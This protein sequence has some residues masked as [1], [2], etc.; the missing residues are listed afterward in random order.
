MHICS[1]CGSCSA[2]NK[3]NTDRVRLKNLKN[4]VYKNVEPENVNHFQI[5]R[6]TLYYLCPVCGF[7]TTFSKDEAP[8]ATVKF[9]ANYPC[10]NCFTRSG[11]DGFM[12]VISPDE[13]ADWDP[14]KSFC[15]TE[16]EFNRQI[17]SAVLIKKFEDENPHIITGNA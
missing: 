11:F 6:F 4:I 7:T 15:V 3:V 9:M 5:Y 14:D 2:P 1:T 10:Y 8:Y 13:C 16:E 12:A 17:L